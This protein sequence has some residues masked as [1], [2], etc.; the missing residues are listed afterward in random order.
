MRKRKPRDYNQDMLSKMSRST[1]SKPQPPPS[2]MLVSRALKTLRPPQIPRPLAEE[3]VK[4]L[5]STEE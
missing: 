5:I 1:R 3:A 4:E 2:V